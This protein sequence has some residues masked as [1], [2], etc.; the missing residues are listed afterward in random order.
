MQLDGKAEIGEVLGVTGQ[1]IGQDL[2][3]IQEVGKLSKSQLAEG[4][5]IEEV[6]PLT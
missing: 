3:D 1:R 4:L 5:P 2:K 6:H